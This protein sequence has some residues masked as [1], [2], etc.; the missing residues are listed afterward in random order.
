MADRVSP[1]PAHREIHPVRFRVVYALL[2]VVLGAA[3]GGLIVLLGRPASSSASWSTWKP[4]GSPGER[5]QQIATFV[6]HRYR[7]GSG[8]QLVGVVAS[9]ARVGDVP[10]KYVALAQG[11]TRADIS[12]VSANG[13]VMFQLCG[14]GRNCAVSEGKPSLARQYLL[15]RESLELALYTFKYLDAKRV[16]TLLPGKPGTRPNYALFLKKEDFA[17]ALD[18][19]LGRTL[20]PHAQVTTRT[21]TAAESTVIRTLD[22]RHL[23]LFRFEQ[24]PDGSAVLVLASPTA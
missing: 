13:S 16:I 6:G 11:Q 20:R 5:M 22:E 14:L 18:K 21:L 24:A 3:V 17:Q 1:S 4:D 9:T 19:P 7:L 10:I 15:Q 23:Y 12:V 2:A 8:R